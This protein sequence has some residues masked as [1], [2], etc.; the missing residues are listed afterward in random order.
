MVWLACFDVLA[1]RAGAARWV[2]LAE[3][4]TKA[5]RE[6]DRKAAA[7]QRRARLKASVPGVALAILC[8]PCI[9][10]LVR[11][12][13]RQARRR[14]EEAKGDGLDVLGLSAEEALKAYDTVQRRKSAATMS[15]QGVWVTCG[16]G[17]FVVCVGV[18]VGVGCEGWVSGCARGVCA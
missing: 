3:I 16:V 11:W 6:R 8:S 1:R 9:K 15:A 2:R 5:R 4:L 12:R 14:G 10:A 17:V 13:A 7:E 18:G